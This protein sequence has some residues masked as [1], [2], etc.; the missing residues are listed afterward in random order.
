M[1]NIVKK[2]KWV[3][4]LICIFILISYFELYSKNKY[5]CIVC[6]KLITKQA[7][8]IDGKYYHPECFRCYAC[9]EPIKDDYVK[10]QNGN[11]YHKSCF[12]K[13]KQNPICEY[14]KKPIRDKK[15]IVYQNKSYHNDCFS[16]HIA[17]L[18]DIC[19]EPLID[20]AITDFW[21]NRFHIRHSYEYPICSVCGRLVT[22]DGIELEKNRWICSVCAQTSVT[23]PEKARILLERVRD[24]MASFGIIIITLGLRIELVSADRLP[25]NRNTPGSNPYAAA[26]WNE[27]KYIQGDERATIFVLSGLPEDF[28]RGVIAHELMHI[29]Q[30][31]NNAENLPLDLKEGSANWASSLIFNRMGSLRGKFFI[32]SYEKSNDP[33]YGGGYRKIAKYA[34]NHGVNGVLELLKKEASNR[35]KD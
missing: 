12:E 24:E 25:G 8:I 33:I 28:M 29:W 18:C 3:I 14:C 30:H 16:K 23:N 20:S 1:I 11:Y 6:G 31:E 27:G 7:V 4:G 10:D 19:G 17:P 21:G 15:Y 5:V 2:W 9:G 13:L 22:R 35:N 32:N 26:F 34:D